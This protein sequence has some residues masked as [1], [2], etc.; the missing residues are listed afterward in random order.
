MACFVELPFVYEHYVNHSLW[1]VVD[2]KPLKT[3]LLSKLMTI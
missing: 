1:D 3:L 2:G